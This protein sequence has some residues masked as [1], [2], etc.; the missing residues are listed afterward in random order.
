LGGFTT[1]NTPQMTAALWPLKI[2]L[3]GNDAAAFLEKALI[4]AAIAE[5]KKSPC[6]PLITL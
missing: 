2:D 4:T 6:T 5:A 3:L 1:P